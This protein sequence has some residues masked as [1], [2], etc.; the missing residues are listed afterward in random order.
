[1]ISLARRTA[2]KQNLCPPQVSFVQAALTEAL[3]I[4]S[5]SVDCILSNCVIN[6]LPLSGKA[7][8]L[9]ELHRVLKPG[10]RLVLDDVR[11]LSIPDARD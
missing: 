3:P 8:L 9:K 4:A 10:G 7:T 2:K 11:I 5:D 6:L 1:M